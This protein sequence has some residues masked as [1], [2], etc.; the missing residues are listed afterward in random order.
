MEPSSPGGAKER[1]FSATLTRRE[2]HPQGGVGV[3]EEEV[4]GEAHAQILGRGY[5]TEG[6]TGAGLGEPTIKSIPSCQI[7][8]ILPRADGLLS[9]NQY[10]FSVEWEVN[11]F[12]KVQFSPFFS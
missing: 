3:L 7:F 11:S 2:S 5:F 9:L 1:P 8:F 10:N 4:G 12:L 6:K